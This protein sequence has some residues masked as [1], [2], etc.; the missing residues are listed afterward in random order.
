MSSS[1]N[2][3]YQLDEPDAALGGCDDR[4]AAAATL[5]RAEALQG[6]TPRM[7]DVAS[8]WQYPLPKQAHGVEQRNAAC[9]FVE[10]WSF[11]KTQVAPGALA[12]ASQLDCHLRSQC[13]PL[14]APQFSNFFR[15]TG[16][17][18]TPVGRAI[19]VWKLLARGTHLVLMHSGGDD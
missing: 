15:V 19:S 8:D 18:C 13:A 7:F 4:A 5:S 17:H 3:P 6:I 1:H 14:G 10:I 16:I 12:G 11:S 9:R 2:T